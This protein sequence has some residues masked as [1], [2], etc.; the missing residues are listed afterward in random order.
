MGTDAKRCSFTWK[1]VKLQRWQTEERK[2]PN[3]RVSYLR[4]DVDLLCSI[5]VEPAHVDLTVKV[6]DVADNGVVLHVLKVTEGQ[7]ISI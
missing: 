7:T 6:T 1:E 4:L 5:F 2:T 3:F